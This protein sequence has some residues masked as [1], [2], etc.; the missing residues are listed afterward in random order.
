M[1]CLLVIEHPV[2]KLHV[3]CTHSAMHF[4]KSGVQ[5]RGLAESIFHSY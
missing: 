5:Q 1:K 3:I 2:I 4:D